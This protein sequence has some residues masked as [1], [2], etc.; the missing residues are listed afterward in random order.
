MIKDKT[1]RLVMFDLDGT[2]LPMDLNKYLMDYGPRLGAFMGKFG[3]DPEKVIKTVLG[4]IPVM[5]ANDG[6]RTNEEVFWDY[7]ASIFGPESIADYHKYDEFYLTE[8]QKVQASCG[9]N[10]EA[11]AL[12]H[13][14]QKANVRLVLAT[15]PFFLQPATYSRVH[16]AGLEPEDFELV[17]TYENSHFCKPNPAY[18]MEILSKVGL[19]ASECLMVGNDAD[20]DLAAAR[21]GMDTFILTDCLINSKNVDLT[22]IPHGDFSVLRAFL[23]KTLQNAY[24]GGLS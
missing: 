22:D 6:S 23:A 24:T 19:E 17:T 7:F 4:S 12:V 15:N 14:L 11:A 18:Y 8:Y 2:L 9:F 13:D 16:W 5:V 10:P 1:Y 3:F 21:T 20:E